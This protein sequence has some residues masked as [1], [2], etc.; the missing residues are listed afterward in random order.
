MR[1]TGTAVFLALCLHGTCAVAQ[2]RVEGVNP[3]DLLTQVQL[4]GEYNRIDDGTDQ[5][6]LTGKYDYKLAGS[7][8]GINV[9]LPFAIAL[10]GPGVDADGHGDLYTRARY[11]RTIGRWSVGGALEVV[12]PIGSDEFSGGRWQTNPAVLGVYAW[13]ARDITALAHK[14]VLGYI[15]DDAAKPDI[16]QYQWRALQIHIF[17]TGWFAQADVSRW[18]SVVGDTTWYD[19]RA[20][21]GKQL[22]PRTRVQA[23]L[24]K[25]SGDVDNDWALSIAYAVKL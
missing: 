12:V 11:I 4:T 7:S 9:E 19:S 2:T 16:N 13:N 6:M 8:V 24:K 14:R 21:L 1:R 15:E 22:S 3:A 23:E 10:N 18:R 25:L 5:W 17:P 20:S